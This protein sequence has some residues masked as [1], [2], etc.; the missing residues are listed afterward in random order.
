MRSFGD[1]QGPRA[2]LAESAGEPTMDMASSSTPATAS[3]SAASLAHANWRAAMPRRVTWSTLG[4]WNPT[5]QCHAPRL[6]L[7]LY[8]ELRSFVYTRERTAEMLHLSDKCFF[9][10]GVTDSTICEP[11]ERP[12][13][14]RRY[15]S[16]PQAAPLEW[17]RFAKAIDSVPDLLARSRSVFA[18]RLAAMVFQRPNGVMDDHGHGHPWPVRLGNAVMDHGSKFEDQMHAL[19]LLTAQ[20]ERQHQFVIDPRAIV[21]RTRFDILCPSYADL[22]GAHE[23][24]RGPRGLGLMFGQEIFDAQGDMHILT[25]FAAW[26]HVKSGGR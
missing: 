21:I 15:R 1:T 19:V 24:L 8:G 2:V 26:Q 14:C 11:G 7:Y 6:L 18:G 25:S 3:G 17:S 12:G 22:A 16:A 23:Y 4:T 13:L 9:V 20:L 10:L 5:S